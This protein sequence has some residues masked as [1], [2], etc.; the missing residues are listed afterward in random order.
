MPSRRTPGS[1]TAGGRCVPAARRA[2]VAGLLLAA[3]A[4]AQPLRVVSTAP[5]FTE[6]M[7]ALGAGKRLVAVSNF[8][9][10]PPEVSRLPKIGNYLDPNVETIARL[11]PDLVLL[12]DKQPQT[13]N[14]LTAMGIRVL[15]LRNTTLEDTM[16]SV[17]RLGTALGMAHEGERVESQLRARLRAIAERTKGRPRRTLLFVVGRTPGRLDGMMAVGS[18]SYLNELMRIAGGRN[19]LD[20]SR[21]AYP[22]IS[23]EGVIRLD[24]DVIVDM[25][26]MTA[27][28][29]V[30]EAHKRAVVKLW[31][32]QR[33]IR[34][35]Q[36]KSV[37]AVADDIFVV[38]GPRVVEAAEAFA[39]MLDGASGR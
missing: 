37:F 18:G 33:E 27:T 19:V 1:A 35:V 13:V 36:R 17:R 23:L 3:C 22:Q 4:M 26:D 9:H 6:T 28:E 32:A 34:A 10:Y 25:G 30:S 2:A 31:E 29:G 11:K 16:M 38:P 14:Q 21:V 8:C 12:H 20:D 7:F 24:P 39:A 5:S 15:T